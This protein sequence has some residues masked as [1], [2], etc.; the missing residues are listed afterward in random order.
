MKL[1]SG[2]L[3]RCKKTGR[4]PI[5]ADYAVWL[6][7]TRGLQP[8]IVPA[9]FNTSHLDQL[10]KGERKRWLRTARRRF[11]RQQRQAA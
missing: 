11:L 8:A 1:P 4:M 7:N 9:D 5:T 10:P 6:V 3:S 2:Y